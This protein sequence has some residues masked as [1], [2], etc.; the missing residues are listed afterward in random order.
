M[1]RRAPIALLALVLVTGL[2][3]C[4]SGAKTTDLPAA[5]ALLSAAATAMGQ[6]TTVHLAVETAGD[7]SLL[8]VRRVE[9]SLTRDG[10]AQGTVQLEQGGGVA[11]YAFVIVGGKLYLK[12]ATGGYQKY[13]ASFASSVYDTSGILD[14]ERGVAKL[15]ATATR[16]KTE[17]RESVNGTDAYRVS[18]TFEPARVVALVRGA[19]SGAT[20]VVWIGADRKLL[21]RARFVLAATGGKAPATVTVT[22]TEIDKPVSISAP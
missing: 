16:P 14:P 6:V 4:T 2:A 7:V 17:A 1:I 12:G 3:G 11:E 13:D 9:G 21:L 5:D 22:F 19:G 15:L 18:A 10:S 8:P 20:G